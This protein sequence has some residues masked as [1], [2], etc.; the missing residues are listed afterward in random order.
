MYGVVVVVVVV[1]VEGCTGT[2]ARHRP[3]SAGL[4]CCAGERPD[5]ILWAVLSH[6][7]EHQNPLRVAYVQVAGPIPAPRAQQG[8]AGAQGLHTDKQPGDPMHV[9][10]GAL[11]AV[12]EGKLLDR[13][14]LWLAKTPGNHTGQLWCSR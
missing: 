4:G 8:W 10:P 7:P 5:F 13:T 9:V 1:V 6:L 3:D 11:L 12:G 2:R 14:P